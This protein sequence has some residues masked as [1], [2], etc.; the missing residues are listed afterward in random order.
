MD[1]IVRAIS[2]DGLV[3]AAAICSRDLTE[4]A[5]QIHK[6]LPVGTAALGRTAADKLI[7][8]IEHPRVTLPEQIRVSGK[9]LDGG[10]VSI[11]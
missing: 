11:L 2:S 10:S 9:L 6:L 8:L 1:R 3:Q 4:R 7:E 5:R